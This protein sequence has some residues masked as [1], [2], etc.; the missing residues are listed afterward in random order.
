MARWTAIVLASLAAILFV[1]WLAGVRVFVI[2]PIGAVPDGVT[3][4][5]FGAPGLNFVDSPDA[6]CMRVQ[7]GVNLLCRGAVMAGVVKNSTLLVRLPFWQPLYDLTG[8]PDVDG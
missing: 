1:A 8:A 6:V 7:G 2:Q 4:I 5:I 3:L